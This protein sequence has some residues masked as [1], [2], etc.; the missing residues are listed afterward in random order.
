MREKRKRRHAPTPEKGVGGGGEAEAEASMSLT[1][2]E[3]LAFTYVKKIQQ[4]GAICRKI[5]GA[6]GG[7]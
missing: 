3:R 7:C 6:V 5:A 1:H 2:D 4:G